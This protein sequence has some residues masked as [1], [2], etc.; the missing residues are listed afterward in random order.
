MKLGRRGWL[1]GLGLALALLPGTAH[2]QGRGPFAD[3]PNTHWAYEA[4][5]KLANYGIFTGY[6]D[7]TFGGSRAIT[8]YE[9]AIG[10][11]RVLAEVERLTSSKVT[12]GAFAGPPGPRGPQGPQGPP[13]PAGPPAAPQAEWTRLL[14]ETNAL[15]QDLSTLRDSFT[16]LREQLRTLRGDLNALTEETQPLSD[17]AAHLHRIRHRVL[18]ERGR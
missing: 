15:R 6:P 11:Q 9:T 13:G 8:R 2:A 3:V 7:E 16:G 14:S 1:A 17:R 10:L 18:L 12:P 4:V 5:S